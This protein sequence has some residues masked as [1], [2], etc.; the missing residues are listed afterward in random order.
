MFKLFAA[1]ST[2]AGT[3]ALGK[4]AYSGDWDWVTG[5]RK[6]PNADWASVKPKFHLIF[7]LVD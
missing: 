5:G 7:K 6:A 2:A 4:T 3:F 1:G